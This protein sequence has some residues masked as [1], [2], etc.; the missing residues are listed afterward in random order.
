MPVP[1]KRWLVTLAIMG[2]VF[3]YRG[4]RRQA[5]RQ[6]I[7]NL[8]AFDLPSAGLYD[9]LVTSLLEGFYRR[10]AEEVVALN[11]STLVLE[12]G[13][14]PGRLAVL[15]AQLSPTIR[16][17]GVDISPSMVERAARRA[18][19]AGLSE[20]VEFKVGDVADLRFPNGHFDTVVSTLSLHHWADP[21]HGL[22]EIWRVLKPGGE[23]HIYDLSAWLWMHAYIREELAELSGGTPFGM[24]SVEAFRWPGPIPAF[25]RL[26]LRRG[27]QG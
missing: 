7:N 27:D 16:V 26:V 2:A 12:V 18:T 4:I 25:S 11:P 6:L 24:A 9:T 22:A 1:R 13:S 19:E 20:R 21:S 3:L 5:F 8:R 15:M 23:A 14:G 10:V 17:I